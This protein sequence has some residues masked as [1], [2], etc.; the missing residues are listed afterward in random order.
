MVDELNEPLGQGRRK[1]DGSHA[2]FG[3]IALG[4]FGVASL[5]AAFLALPN[6]PYGGQPRAVA[7]IEPAKPVE[8]AP[9][10]AP[11]P[12]GVTASEDRTQRA[13]GPHDQ[14]SNA[15]EIEQMSGVKVTRAGSP[16]AP[17]ALIIKIE[18][19][20]AT[21]LSPAPDKRLVEKGRYGPLPKIG[22]DGVKP[23]ELYARPAALAAGAKA[24]APRVAIVVG[25][26]GLSPSVTASAIDQLPEAVTLAFAPYGSNV[27]KLAARARDHGHETVLQAPM[28]PFDYPQNNPGPHT[29][30]TSSQSDG[31]LDD[32]HWLMSR[33]TGYAGVMN[34]LGARFTAD[35]KSLTAALADVAARGLFFLDDGTSPQS[36]IGA[37]ATRLSMPS[38]RVD[39]VIDAKQSPAAIDA[40]LAQLEA[41]AREKGSAIGFANAVPTT[42]TRLAKFARDLERRGCVLAPVTAT[43]ARPNSFHETRSILEK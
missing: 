35:E 15:N 33:F 3:K 34:F 11:P 36:L 40:A 23:M 37:T 25:G 14:M 2:A 4:L 17:G 43:L 31:A 26:L 29:L 20:G 6:D 24:G 13:A 5:Y 30:L 19:R 39:I 18:R 32:L 21:G 42:I 41:Q 12:P 38:A 22:A 7:R 10:Q 16:D 27:E 9:S 8:P 1:R 28:E